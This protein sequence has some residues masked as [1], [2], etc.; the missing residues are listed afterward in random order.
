MSRFFGSTLDSA[1]LRYR[2]LAY[3]VGTGLI[4]LVFVGMPL[5]YWA[6]QKSVVEV[7][8]PIH[9]F[10]YIVYLVTGAEM[11]VRCRWGL[12]KL[13]AVVL[14][15]LVP[16]VAFIVERQAVRWVP[17]DRLGELGEQGVQA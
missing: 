12:G 9:G 13:M 6:H 10:L 16:T 2:A 4:V 3:A 14:A 17:S 1:V 11:A 8:G 5:Q 15:G 7:V